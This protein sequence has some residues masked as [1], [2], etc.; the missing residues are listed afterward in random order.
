[1]DSKELKKIGFKDNTKT[2]DKETF[3]EFRF[4]GKEVSIEISGTTLVEIT[5]GR[6]VWITVPGC[7]TLED[8][9]QLMRLFNLKK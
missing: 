1:M 2:I 6:N 7:Q 3:T 9:K 4:D 5:T 8:V